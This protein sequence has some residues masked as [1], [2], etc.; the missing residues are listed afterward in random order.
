MHVSGPFGALLE[1]LESAVLEQPWQAFAQRL[2][3]ALSLDSR[4]RIGEVL[5]VFFL[6]EVF[7]ALLGAGDAVIEQF[8]EALLASLNQFSG[9]TNAG[10]C[11]ERFDGG[12]G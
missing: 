10:V 1:L 9:Q 8:L 6:Q 7:A 3:G 2:V 11:K 5:R 4:P 12:L